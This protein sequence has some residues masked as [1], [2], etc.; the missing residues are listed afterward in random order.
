MLSVQRLTAVVSGCINIPS[1]EFHSIKNIKYL[2][3][4]TMPVITRV[5]TVHQLIM[6]VCVTVP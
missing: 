2:T 1:K 6:N 4:V 5:W 3:N